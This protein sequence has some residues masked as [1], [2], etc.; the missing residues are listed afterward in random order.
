[1]HFNASIWFHLVLSD[2]W[3][4][5]NV[6]PRGILLL[7]LASVARPGPKSPIDSIDSIDSINSIDWC[8]WCQILSD[9]LRF[10]FVIR[11]DGRKRKQHITW[12]GSYYIIYI[13]THSNYFNT[14]PNVCNSSCHRCHRWHRKSKV[15]ICGG[16]QGARVPFP[17]FYMIQMDKVALLIFFCAK[18][19]EANHWFKWISRSRFRI[20]SREA[21]PDG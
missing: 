8:Q 20:I 7:H 9:I 5:K 2:F 10:L 18:H 17:A 15:V 21:S 3:H 12:D 16:H 1:M 19:P 14:F 13:Y 11:P 6:L 4:N